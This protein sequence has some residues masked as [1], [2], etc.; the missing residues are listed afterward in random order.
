[1]KKI[2]LTACAAAMLTVAGAG[3]AEAGCY[4]MGLS[5]YHWYR[6]CIGPGFLYPHARHCGWHNGYRTCWYN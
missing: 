3:A 2:V 1:M 5:G 4:R 6:Y